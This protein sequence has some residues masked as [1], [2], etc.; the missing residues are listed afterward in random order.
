[1]KNY[2][3]DLAQT[4]L[5]VGIEQENIEKLLGCIQAKV[6][7]YKKDELIIEEG[8]K[9]YDFGIMLS[10]HGRAFKIDTMGRI[11]IIT[12]LKKGSEIGVILAA[13]SNHKSPVSVQTEEDLSVLSVPFDGLITRCKNN[14]PQHDRLLRNYI[15]IVAEK[16]M[17]LHERIDCLLKPT[18]REKIMTYLVRVS[19]EQGCRTI[20]IPFDR[21]AMSEYLNI[22]R[23]ALS[24]ELSKMKRDGLIDFH[25]S[26]FKL[27]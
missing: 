19:R 23:S 25:K 8:S 22:E 4:A 5:F 6:V 14:C 20:A 17:V 9:V 27:L 3:E 13:G 10:G 7:E 18:V 12:L 1:M 24:R 15:N 16:G 2:V 26:E 11:I 21:Y